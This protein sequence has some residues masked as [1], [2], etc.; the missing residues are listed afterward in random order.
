MGE[1]RRR[2]SL[3]PPAF[4]ALLLVLDPDR[5]KAGERFELLRA[6]L[7]RYFTFEC[8]RFPERWADETI[9]RVAKRLVEVGGISGDLN[10]YARGVARLVLLEA[11]AH[12]R[13]EHDLTLPAPEPAHASEG[14][15]QALTLCLAAMPPTAREIIE[16][17]YQT[18]SDAASKVR[19]A[20][21]ARLGVSAEA[22]RSR[23]LRIR[24]HLE[25]CMRQQRNSATNPEISTDQ[26]RNDLF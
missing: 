8:T 2:W 3:T 7:L 6:R 1:P 21:A 19:A 24:K 14:D 25:R 5:E 18:H 23:A 26:D 4:E 22:L 12:E 17:Y 11:R 9:D 10:A 15:L 20:L 13:R 16:G